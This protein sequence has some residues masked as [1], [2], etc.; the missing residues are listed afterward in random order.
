MISRR[1]AIAIAAAYTCRFSIPGYGN[2]RPS[3][4]NDSLY[5]FLFEND[6]EAW[7][8]NTVKT[9]HSPRSLKEWGMRIH[10]GETL[11]KATPNWDW[12]ARAKLG[13]N[14]L[15]NLAVAFLNSFVARNDAR[16]TKHYEKVALELQRSL[17]LDGYVYG[18]H[19][20]LMPESDVLDV[21]EERGVLERL[22]KS[23]QLRRDD[24]AFQFLELSETHYFA[25]RWEDCIANARKF[26]ELTL[27]ECASRHSQ[28][29]SGSRLS[30]AV[31]QRPVK[32]RD[33][34]ERENL[35][36]KKERELVDKTYGLL[37]HTGSHP[38][39]AKHDQARLL[40][41]IA[42]TVSQFVMLRT[43]GALQ[44]T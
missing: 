7:F 19:E 5:D 35:L 32:V 30:D 11:A 33:Y 23:L 34:L 15:R 2:K 26:F 38:Y 16:T 42:L 17:E 22:Y 8:C 40:R 24:E 29:S 44:G 14:Y 27:Q 31:A 18:D 37:S 20:L 3:V 28:V 43:E 6:F 41:Q 13:Q 21:E 12:H 36:E 39:M 25:S 1:S 9:I 4:F 10:T